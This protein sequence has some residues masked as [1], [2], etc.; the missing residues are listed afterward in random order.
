MNKQRHTN[1]QYNVNGY[2]SWTLNTNWMPEYMNQAFEELSL[3]EEVWII[4]ENDEIIP[5][6][7]EDTRIDFKTQLNDKLI[8]YTMKVKMSHQVI[9]NIL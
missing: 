4:L 9:K 7:K 1:K 6:V 3:S 2:E 5:I 8:Q